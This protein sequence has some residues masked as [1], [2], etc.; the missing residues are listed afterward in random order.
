MSLLKFIP[1]TSTLSD[2]LII[3]STGSIPIITKEL[4]LKQTLLGG[5]SFRWIEQN[6]NEFIGVLDTYIVRLQHQNNNLRYTFFINND[7]LIKLSNDNDRRVETALILHNYFQ[8]KIK[9][10]E[11][12]D[13]WCKSDMRFEKGQIPIGIRV[14]AQEPLENLISFICSSN[15]NVQRISKMIKVFCDEYGKKIG[16]L[17]GITYHQFPTLDELDIP[18]LEKRLRELNFGYRARYIQEAVKFLKYTAGGTLFFDR[19]KTLSVKEA[20]NQLSKMMGVGRKVADCV[21]LMSLGKQDVVPVDTHI[22][23]IAMTHYGHYNENV[24]KQQLTTANY[25]DISS[26][27]EQLWQPLSGWAQAAAFSNELRLSSTPRNSVKSSVLSLKRSISSQDILTEKLFKTID[28]NNQCQSIK[29]TMKRDKLRQKN[30]LTIEPNKE[31]LTRPKRNIKPI[32][33]F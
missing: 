22:H 33:R 26:F 14:L 29:I 13:K 10:C 6:S 11:L 4:N 5:Q 24:K 30:L 25:N 7:N 20:R 17:N 15:N 19:L 31:I 23:S 8:L 1:S 12:F 2:N 32:D 16:T 9:L 21:L 18:D 3:Y 28:E 27:F